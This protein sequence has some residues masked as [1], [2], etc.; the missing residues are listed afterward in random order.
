VRG[1]RGRTRHRSAARA[2]TSRFR[3]TRC[4]PRGSTRDA[5]RLAHEP[6]QPDRAACRVTRSCRIAAAAPQRSSRGRGLCGLLGADAARGRCAR[7]FPNL[8][9]GRTF[10]K[11]YGLAGC[12]PARWWRTPATLAPIRASCR[13]TASTPAWRPRCR[14]PSPTWRT[15]SGISARSRS[16]SAALRGLR[17][18]AASLLAERCELRA[19]ASGGLRHPGPGAAR[20]GHPRARQVEDPGCA[21]A[22]ASR[23]ASWR[24]PGLHRG[25]RGGPVRRGVVDRGRPRRRSAMK[26]N[27]DGRG[28]Y[29]V[30]TG[31]RFFDHMLELFARHGAFD[32]ALATTAT[33]TSTST[34]P[35][36]TSGSPS[37]RRYRSARH[38]PR[39]QPRRL[40]RHAD[41]RDAGGRRHRPRRA[42]PHHVDLKLKRE[43]A[44]ATSRQN[45][46]TT[47]SMAS[48][49]RRA[50]TSTSRCSTAARA[51]TTSRPVQGV[52]PRAAR[53]R[54]AGS[55][56]GP[57]AAQHE[58]A[59]VKDRAGGLRRRQPGLGAQGAAAAGAEVFTPGPGDLR[60]LRRRGPGRRALRRNSRPRRGWRR[61][62]LAAW[63]RAAAPRDL[64]RDAVAV[65]RQRRSAGVA[66]LGLL[67]APASASSEAAAEGAAR[68][69]ESL[70]ATR[71]EAACSTAST[72]GAYAYFTHSYAAP[73][74]ADTVATCRARHAHLRGGV[75]RGHVAGVQFH[76]E[77]SGDAGL[78][79][80]PTS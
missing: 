67:G 38:A 47:S 69:V 63:R 29:E 53:R 76:P 61:P 55:A 22:C 77:K 80:L 17:S 20:A 5:A 45:W 68:R 78:R 50:P 51:T 9:V 3:S 60:A 33:S 56:D 21:A 43:A 27:L 13:R 72:D 48:P 14:R 32:L 49:R 64:P 36:R 1:C 31:I 70:L 28:R 37:A 59:A 39:H 40:L 65:R 35:S 62:R 15:T 2:R 7:H 44:S 24:H 34:T 46:C 58:G 12:A 74:D 16:R 10:A 25:A 11:A 4:W 71:A 52:R 30:A 41:G 6:Q 18:A 79:I 19:R 42:G 54:G 57:D 26:L 66:G 23:P 73:G 8:V 75:E